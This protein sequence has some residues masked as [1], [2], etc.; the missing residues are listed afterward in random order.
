MNKRFCKLGQD[1][2]KAVC[3][4]AICGAYSCADDYKWDDEN[5]SFL[6]PSIYEYLKTD[7]SY[8]NFVKLIDDL[9]YKEVLGRTGSKTLFVADDDAFK[10]IYKC[11]G[12]MLLRN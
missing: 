8:K 3:L 5:P 2:A 9:D 11:Y 12:I 10:A 6:G 1:A 4:V 7:G